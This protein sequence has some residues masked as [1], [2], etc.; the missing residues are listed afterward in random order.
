LLT[1]TSDNMLER[2]ETGNQKLL[3][4]KVGIYE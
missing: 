2:K 1:V 4:L 3:V